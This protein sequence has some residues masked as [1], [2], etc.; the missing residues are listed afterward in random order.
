MPSRLWSTLKQTFAAWLSHEGPRF[1]AALSF[2]S[3]VSLA[4]LVILVIALVSLVIG[5]SAAQD[6]IINEVQ[7]FI[8][9]DGAKAVRTVIEHSKEP[10]ASSFASIVGIVT[11][12]FGASG[13][14][15]ELQ[16]ALNKI[17]DVRRNR[18]GN[19]LSLIGVYAFAFGMTLA[20]GFLL[21]VSLVVSAVLAALGRFA[22][23]I[24]P[25]PESV[26]ATLNFLVSFSGISVLF[27]LLFKYVPDIKIRWRDVWE[28]A[29]VT[30]VLFTV[31]KSLI[32][33]YLGKAAVGSAYGAAGSLIVVVLWVY[34]SAMIFLFGAEFTHV[35]ARD[36]RTEPT[37]YAN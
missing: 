37:K 15:A 18:E 3:L 7:A 13:V 33:V 27:A 6:Q 32:G 31:G 9:A 5:H 25:V 12:L 14:F 23:E 36:R 29:I 8:G 26:M 10:A 16:S 28:G 11:L 19:L 24:L 20:V 1:G 2:Y 21:L 22:G 17:W 34:Y 4:P 35:R 30:A